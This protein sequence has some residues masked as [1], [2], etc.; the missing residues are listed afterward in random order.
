MY[1]FFRLH[2]CKQIEE[3]YR[4]A[5]YLSDMSYQIIDTYIYFFFIDYI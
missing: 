2:Q 1:I 5:K 4:I 3:L